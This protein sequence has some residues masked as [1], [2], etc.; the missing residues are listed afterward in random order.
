MTALF[1]EFL[2]FLI[3]EKNSKTFSEF[4]KTEPETVLH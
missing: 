4:R 1:N 2:S 3:L